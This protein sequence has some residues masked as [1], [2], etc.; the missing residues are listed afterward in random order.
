MIFREH[1]EALIRRMENSLACMLMGFDGIAVVSAARPGLDLDLELMG[2]EISAIIKQLRNAAF[3]QQF[4][5]ARE[6]VFRS[7]RT[8]IL[9]KA[10]TEDYFVALIL[11][12]DAHVG[13]GR[14]LLRLI[15]PDL[16]KELT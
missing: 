10:I 7:N 13:K 9:L 14:F 16:L 3:V 15:E 1:F 2:A 12:P 6:F 5:K 8:T 11:N 4:G